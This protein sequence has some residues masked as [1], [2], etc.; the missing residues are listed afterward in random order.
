MKKTNKWL[1]L[2]ILLLIIGPVIGMFYFFSIELIGIGI[3]MLELYF[4]IFG[5]IINAQEKETKV[6]QF[7]FILVGSII[8][9]V[10]MFNQFGTEEIVNFINTDGIALAFALFCMIVGIGLIIGPGIYE[11]KALKRYSKL[12]LARCIDINAHPNG[13]KIEASPIWK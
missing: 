5:F 10:G 2:L 1:G 12:V 6:P 11:R 7:I 13:S 9:I 8:A 3:L 4:I